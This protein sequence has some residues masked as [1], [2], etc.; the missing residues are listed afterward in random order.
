MKFTIKQ[1]SIKCI[2]FDSIDN[3]YEVTENKEKKTTLDK[4]AILKQYEQQQKKIRIIKSRE[5]EA[6]QQE[7]DPEDILKKIGIKEGNWAN[8]KSKIYLN[9]NT[10]SQKELLEQK[11]YIF[12]NNGER[13]WK[14]HWKH[15]ID[16]NGNV[17]WYIKNW[18]LWKKWVV[19]EEWNKKWYIKK[20]KYHSL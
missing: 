7:W 1:V 18:L 15:M 6:K 4:T 19:D 5:Q 3:N 16:D 8:N 9:P 20:W 13:V 14:I 10:A 12:D 2:S 11:G 17:V